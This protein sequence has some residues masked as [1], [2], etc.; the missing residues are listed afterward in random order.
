M[1][2]INWICCIASVP[3]LVTC[4]WLS[5]PLALSVVTL[6]YYHYYFR[7]LPARL[8]LHAH[9]YIHT[10]HFYSFHLRSIF[11][12]GFFFLFTSST[13]LYA[14]LILPLLY[15]TVAA[16]SLYLYLHNFVLFYIYFFIYRQ[17]RTDLHA[18]TYAHFTCCVWLSGGW[19]HCTG[20]Y[21][22]FL[23]EF[24]CLFRSF[25]FFILR[26]VVFFLFLFRF[27]FFFVHSVLSNTHAY[28]RT[29]V[30]I[31]YTVR[32]TH[33]YTHSRRMFAVCALILMFYVSARFF[34]MNA[35]CGLYFWCHNVNRSTKCVYY[36]HI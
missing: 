32:K 4:L 29:A 3:F 17:K 14:I 27:F 2:C 16:H 11:L 22:W 33:I 1:A 24:L 9:T 21:I 30:H 12:V 7:F 28:T 31:C 20:V 23:C 34:G 15:Y 10:H 8:C 19:S 35:E 36:T 25:F 6:F 26:L 5:F 13:V 18:H